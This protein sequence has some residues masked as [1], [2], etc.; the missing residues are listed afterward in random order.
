M[1][2]SNLQQP[3]SLKGHDTRLYN[4]E[5]PVHEHEATSLNWEQS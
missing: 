3:L 5:T 2:L 1:K 4:F